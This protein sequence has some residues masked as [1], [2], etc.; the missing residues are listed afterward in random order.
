MKFQK[1]FLGKNNDLPAVASARQQSLRACS[2]DSL[3]E[4]FPFGTPRTR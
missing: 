3:H 4:G 1:T 2:R